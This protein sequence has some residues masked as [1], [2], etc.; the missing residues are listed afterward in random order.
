MT[1]DMIFEVISDILKKN[2][3]STE[4]LRT[5]KNLSDF[6]IWLYTEA[7]FKFKEG[8][9]SYFYVKKDFQDEV[10]E[11]FETQV[12]SSPVGWVRFKIETTE[13]IMKIEQVIVKVYDQVTISDEF[14]C[15]HLYQE[16]SDQGKCISPRKERAR[17]CIYRKNLEAGLNFYKDN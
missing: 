5:V 6:T 2:G 11:H 8:K 16:C 15:C 4:G 13:D 1:N 7:L 3:K 17:A 10:A 12:V 14:A 9:V